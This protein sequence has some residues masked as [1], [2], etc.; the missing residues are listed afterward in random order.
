V[1]DV[2]GVL[3]LAPPKKL[4]FGSTTAAV[5]IRIS[6]TTEFDYGTNF[7]SMREADKLISSPEE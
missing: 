7:Y 6:S 4:F 3:S 2:P 1:A 5:R